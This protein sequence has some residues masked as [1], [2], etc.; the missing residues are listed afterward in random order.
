MG[1]QDSR[2]VRPGWVVVTC[3][4]SS[5]AEVRSQRE[6]IAASDHPHHPPAREEK[7]TSA[8]ASPLL[9]DQQPVG[10]FDSLYHNI[11]YN[12][13]LAADFP[14]PAIAGKGPEGV[15]KRLTWNKD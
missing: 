5:Q 1:N 9:R 3:G 15:K 13:H 11:M 14:S 2:E 7:F 12:I 6:Q 4:I 8:P 10:S